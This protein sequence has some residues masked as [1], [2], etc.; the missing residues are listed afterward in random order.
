ME[1]I[2]RWHEASLVPEH[3]QRPWIPSLEVNLQERI[4]SLLLSRNE[5]RPPK[6]PCST[7]D[8]VSLSRHPD[9]TPVG[10][11]LAPP[12]THSFSATK[13]AL[14]LE[15]LRSLSLE[16]GATRFDGPAGQ[17]EEEDSARSRRHST[18]TKMQSDRISLIEER[19]SSA[20]SGVNRNSRGDLVGREMS[21]SDGLNRSKSSGPRRPN[22]LRTSRISYTL[23]TVPPN[24]PRAIE[25]RLRPN[26]QHVPG[27]YRSE[28]DPALI[29]TPKIAS[30]QAGDISNMT[31]HLHGPGINAIDALH[32]VQGHEVHQVAIASPMLRAKI[33]QTT[34]KSTASS[35][36]PQRLLLDSLEPQA[37]MSQ[38]TEALLST[39]TNKDEPIQEPLEAPASV[40]E[41][42]TQEPVSKSGGPR[43]A[44][45][46]S[47]LRTLKDHSSSLLSLHSLALHADD[48]LE[49]PDAPLLPKPSSE[50]S[51][52]TPKLSPVSRAMSILSDISAKATPRRRSTTK[53]NHTATDTANEQQTDPSTPPAEGQKGDWIRQMIG[54]RSSTSLEPSNLTARPSQHKRGPGAIP[55]KNLVKTESTDEAS[56][57][58]K[59]QQ[60]TESFQNVIVDLESLLKE[61]IDIAGRASSRENNEMEPAP[62][63][64][65]RNGYRR[66]STATSDERSSGSMVFGEEDDNASGAHA[67]AQTQG[68]VFVVEPDDEDLYHG[69][70]IN[71]R[72]ATPFPRSLAPTR[73]Q[74][75]V[76]NFEIEGSEAQRETPSNDDPARGRSQPMRHLEP[77]NS[78]DWAFVKRPML[79]PPMPPA[80]PPSS[81]APGK[82][83]HSFLIRDHGLTSETSGYTVKS[84]QRPPI[85]PRSSS[86]RLKSRPAPK[87]PLNVP[88]PVVSSGE[89]ESTS[90]PYVA[91]FGNSA[92]QYHPVIIEA[93]AGESSRTSQPGP[94]PYRREDI[95]TSLRPLQQ[96]GQEQGHSHPTGRE[97]R[98]GYSLKGRHHFEIREPHGFSLSRSHRRAPI[99]RDWSISRKRFVATITCFN[100][101]LLGLIIGIYAGEVPAIQ[102]AVADDHHVVILGNVVFFIGLALTTALFWPLPLLHG[103]KPYTMTALTIL[104]PLLFPQALAINGSRNPYVATYRVGLLVP[105]A[106]AGLVMGFANINF[107]ATLLDLFGASLQSGNPHQEM[108]NENDV[109][110]HGGGM[111][112]WLGIWTW[113]SIG[114]IGIGF[115]IGASIISGLQVSWGFWILIILTASVLLLNVL[116]PEVRR[117]AYR[118]SMAEVRTGDDPSGVSRRIARGEIKMHLDSTGPIWWWEEVWAGHV[119]CVRMLKQPGF[120]VLAFYLGWIYGQI[121]LV[122]VVGPELFPVPFDRQ[123]T[124]L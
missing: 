38:A 71:A 41:I 25:Q 15:Q 8:Y 24:T 70:F 76:P 88:P 107:K 5:K 121:V 30:P 57:L 47:E 104:L 16:M 52:R 2:S 78:T 73:H 83:Q 117:S 87:R 77:F 67:A 23:R 53:E 10:N 113:C 98:K 44:E 42:E 75:T 1:E 26:T 101:A 84:H 112:V 19:R 45:M 54:K 48:V 85:Q 95:I 56:V 74:S 29:Q 7:P 120:A 97:I 119:L 81:Q 99:A 40:V 39:D 115:W 94:S 122:I 111:G 11:S 18:A 123:L 37:T 118:R 61:A 28:V 93:M 105:R 64:T 20:V 55:P 27:S 35:H 108:V 14:E 66:L 63:R 65:R 3:G 58:R 102:Y 68:H 21:A 114:S 86:M 22:K 36:R 59:Q 92:L 82:E 91:D 100:T 4:R 79:Q 46:Q 90:G 62:P 9:Q 106:I 33:S 69:H 31:Q 6:T 96:Q 116:T 12:R 51:N 80:M 17:F 34:L 103:R 109:R 32:K 60:T 49:S 89:S 110:R 43:L 13:S 72:D 50:K 124:V